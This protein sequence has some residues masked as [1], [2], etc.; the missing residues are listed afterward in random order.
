MR[1]WTKHDRLQED[2]GGAIDD[3]DVDVDVDVVVVDVVVV[4]VNVVAVVVVDDDVD[5]DVDVVV[6]VVDDDVGRRISWLFQ[7][8]LPQQESIVAQVE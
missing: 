6:V 2:G 5:V 3:V 1:S 8:L 7:L 4:V